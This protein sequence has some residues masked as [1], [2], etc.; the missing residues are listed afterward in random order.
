MRSLCL[1]VF[2]VGVLSL[3]GLNVSHATYSYHNQQHGYWQGYGFNKKFHTFKHKKS[4]HGFHHQ[5]WNRAPIAHH[6]RVWLKQGESKSFKLSATDWDGDTLTYKI[7]RDPRHGMLTGDAPNLVYTPRP[8]FYGK[9]YLK[10]VVSDGKKNSY[11]WVKFYVKRNPLQQNKAPVANEQSLTTRVNTSVDIALTGS[12]AENDPLTFS[13]SQIPVHGT[14]S[15]TAPNLVYTPNPNFVGDDAFAFIANDGKKDS[16]PATVSIS[17]KPKPLCRPNDAITLNYDSFADASDWQ[18]NGSANTLTPNADKVLR[19]TQQLSQGGSAFIRDSIR[20]EDDNGFKA[21]FSAAFSFRIP[22]PIGIQDRDGQGADGIVFVLQ[23]MA[24]NVGANGGGIGYQGIKNSLGIEFDTWDNGKVDHYS[25]NHIGI[26]VNGS[27]RSKLIKPI[28]GRFNDGDRRYVWVDYHGDT[29]RLEIRLAKEETRPEKPVMVVRSLDLPKILGK[30]DAFVG[31]TSG[32]GAAGGQHDLIDFQLVNRYAPIDDCRNT[33]PAAD[34]QSLQTNQNQPLDITLTGSD[35]D[36]D[37]V[38]F[39]VVSQPANGQLSGDAP[40]L[41]YTPNLDFIGTD[42]ITFIANDGIVDSVEATIQIT[43]LTV[44][45]APV[46]LDQS[47]TLDEDTIIDLQLTGTDGDNDPLSYTLQSQPQNGTLTGTAP[48]LI[49]TPNA[50]FSG[51]DS[52]TFLVNDG[53]VDSAIATITLT[54]NPMNDAPIA[55]S[56]S[57]ITPEDA[58]LTILLDGSDP[59]GNT[60]TYELVRPAVNGVISGTVPNLVYTPASNFVGSDTFTFKVNDGTADSNEATVTITVTPVNDAPVADDQS[61]TTNEDSPVSIE[62]T[63]SDIDG[64]SLSFSVQAQPINGTLSGTVPNLTYTPNVDFNGNDSF[65]FVVNDGTVDSA[66]ATVSI[67]VNPVNDA[68]TADDQGI[69]TDEDVVVNIALTGTDPEGDAISYVVQ[70][71]PANGTLSGTAPNLTYTPNTDFTGSDSFTFV[72]NDGTIDSAIATVSIVVNPVNDAPTADD[73]SITTDEDVAVNIALTGTDPEGDVLSYVVQNQPANGTLSGTAPNLTYTPNT[74]FAGNDSFTFV[75]NDGTIDSAIATVSITM[76]PINDAPIAND[77]SITTDEDVAVNIILTG[78]DPEGDSL[79]YVVQTQPANGTLSGTAPDLTYTPNA[80]FTGNDSFTFIVNDGAVESTVATVSITVNPTND[81]PTADDQSITT[82]EDVAVNIILTGNDPEGDSLTYVVQTQ[83]ANGTLSGTAPDLTYTPNADFTG[84]DSFTF[85]VNDGTVDSAIATL[86]IVVNS[87]NDAPTADDQSITT[88]EDVAVNIALTGTDPEGDALNYVVQTQPENGSLSGTAP[89][90]TYTPNA[91][92]TGSDTF[93]FVVNDGTVESAVA[94]VSITVNPVNDAPTADDQIITTDEDTAVN[95]IL[96]GADPEGD[97]LT[98][99]VQTQP[100]NGTLSGAAPDLTYTPDVGFSGNDSFTFVVNDGTVNSSIATVFITVNSITDPLSLS[101]TPFSI[102]TV[103]EGYRYEIITN[104]DVSAVTFSLLESP[105]GMQ[106]DDNGVVTWVP[107]QD[108]IGIHAVDA[109]V[110]DANGQQTNQQWDIEVTRGS[111]QLTPKYV[112]ASAN[113]VSTIHKN[114][115]VSELPNAL[116]LCLVVDLSGS[117]GN[118]LPNI[119]NKAP[120]IFDEVKRGIPDTQFCLASFVDYPFGGYGGA[121]D[122][123]H[124]LHQDLTPVREFWLDEVNRLVLRSGGDG[125]ESQLESLYQLATGSGRDVGDAGASVGD[126]PAGLN[127]SFR[128]DAAKIIAITTDAPFHDS[129]AHPGPTLDETVEALN[130]AGIAIIAIKAPGASEQ[131]D[132]LA[133]RTG[134]IVVETSSDS[135]EIADAVIR[136]VRELSRKV[137]HRTVSCDVADIS[138]DKDEAEIFGR[139]VVEFVET[140]LP[141]SASGNCIIEYSSKGEILGLQEINFCE[142]WSE[143]YPPEIISTPSTELNIEDDYYYAVIASDA[144]GDKLSYELIA[145]P[146]GMQINDLGEVTWQPVDSQRGMNRVEVQVTDTDGATDTQVWDIEVGDINRS[147]EIVSTPASEVSLFHEFSYYLIVRDADDDNHVYELVSAPMG[148]QIAGNIISWAPQDGTLGDHEFVVRATDAEGLSDE[149]TFI[150][151]VIP[152]QG[153]EFVSTPATERAYQHVFSYELLAED[154]ERDRVTGYRLGSGSGDAAVSGSTFTWTVTNPVGTETE[155]TVEALDEYGA[156]GQQTFIVKSVEN[157]PMTITSDPALTGITRHEYKYTPT[158]E[159]ADGDA[160]IVELISGP[161]GLSTSGD[162]LVW[163]PT[164]A[165]V[166]NFPVSFRVRD[167]F[168]SQDEQSYVINVTLNQPPEF[169]SD[170]LDKA[171]AGRQYLYAFNATD[172]D[173][174]A[175]SYELITA[176]DGMTQV[177]R[178]LRWNPVQEQIGSSYDVVLQADDQFGGITTQAFT[179]L[180]TGNRAPEFTSTPDFFGRVGEFYFYRAMA[181]D[182]DGDSVI[183]SLDVAPDGMT[184]SGNG[185][186]WTPTATQLGEHEVKVRADDRNG[187]VVTQSFV[188]NV[189]E[190][191]APQFTS[192]PLVNVID[193][194]SYFYRAIATDPDNDSVIYSLTT[195]P[196]GMT[197]SGN[198]IRWTPDV[199]QTGVHDVVILADDRKGGTTEQAYQIT[200][201]SNRAPEFTSSPLE[202]VIEG[203][204]YFYRSIAVDPDGDSLTY[205]LEIAPDGMT[206]SGNFIRWTPDNSQLG[207][208][209]V[210]VV[211]DDRFGKTTTQSFAVTVFENQSP[212]IVAEPNTAGRLGVNY[213]SRLIATDPDGDSVQY[214]LISG[215]TGLSVRTNGFIDWANTDLLLG[216][217]EIVLEAFDQYD[218]VTEYRYRLTIIDSDLSITKAP[219]D[220]TLFDNELFSFRAEAVHFEGRGITYEFTESPDGATI[221]PN[222]GQI[223]WTPTVS[224]LGA[225]PFILRAFSSDG[226]EDT[227]SFTITVEANTNQSPEITSSPVLT[228]QTGVSYEYPVVATDAE[229][230]TLTYSL[231]QAPSGMRVNA[232]SGV[233]SWNVPNAASS[234][235]THP[236]IVRVT[237]ERGKFTEQSYEL[238]IALSNVAP[239]ITSAAFTVGKLGFDYAYP[240]EATDANGDV[241]TYSLPIAPTGMTINTDGLIQ[242]T[243]TT[244][245]VFPVE[246]VV[247]DGEFTD[248]QLFQVAVSPEEPALE[249]QITLSPTIVDADENVL[250]SSSALNNTGRAFGTLTLDGT[251]VV[252][253]RVLPFNWNVSSSDVGEHTVEL[254]VIDSYQTATQTQIFRVRDDNDTDAPFAQIHNIEQDQVITAPVEVVA[255][256]TDSNFA[257]WELIVREVVADPTEFQVLASG[258]T[259]INEAMVATLDP[260]LLRNG[261]YGLILRV[262]DLNGEETLESVIV[263][264]D[265][266]LKVGNFSVTYEDLNIPLAGIPISVRRTYDSRD[267]AKSMDFGFGWSLDYNN[268]KVEESRRPGFGWAQE[269]SGGLIPN[270][271]IEPLGAPIVTVTLPDGDVESFEAAASPRCSQ[272]FPQ[273]NVT[274]VFNPVGDTQSTLTAVDGSAYYDSGNLLKDITDVGTDNYANPDRYRLTSKAGFVFDLDQNLGIR[275]VTDPNGNVLTYTDE[276]IIHSDGKRVDF[277]RDAEGRIVKITDPSGKFLEYDYT[278]AGDLAKAIERDGAETTF[279]YNSSHGLIDIND[280]LGRNI[281]KNI[282]DDAGRLI[283]QEDSDGNRTEFNH[284]VDGRQSIVTDRNGNITQL[285]YDDDG[286]VTTQIDALGNSTSYTH[287]ANGNETSQANALG[288]Q[289]QATFNDRNDQL[290]Q[291]DA[292]GNVTAFEYNDRGKETKLTDARGNAFN[293]VYDDNNNLISVTDPLGN[294]ATTTLNRQGLPSTVTDVLGNTTQFTYD[295][296]G[297]KLTETDSEGNVMRFTRDANGNAL[298][299]TRTRLIAGVATEETTTYEYD[300]R[301]RVVKTIDALGNETQTEYNLVGNEVAQID[302]LGRRTEMEYDAY[303]RLTQTTYPDGTVETKT[304]DPEGNLLTDTDRLGRLMTYEYDALNRLIK[305]TQADGSVTSTEYDAIGRVVAEVDANG[306]RTV[307]EYDAADRRIKTTD[308]LGNETTFAY[309]ADGNMTGMTDANGNTTTYIY[310][311]LDQKVQTTFA[312]TSTM[313]EGLDALSRKTSMTDQAGV[314]TNYEYDKLGRLVKVIDAL[315]QETAY[316]YDSVG[317]KLTQT[318]AEGRTTTW[319]YDA[320]G[321]VISRTLPLGQQETFVYD[322]VGNLIEHTDFKGQTTTHSYDVNNRLTQSLYADGLME[323]FVYDAVGN[324]TQANK[325]ENSVTTTTNYVYDTQNRLSSETQFVG[326]ADEVTLSYVYDAQGNRTQLTEAQGAL[327]RVTNYTFD[328]LN[329]LSTVTDPEANVTTYQYDAVGNRSGMTHANGN[330]VNY[331]YDELNRLTTLNHVDSADAIIKGFAYTLH[332]TGRRTQI[333][334]NSGRTTTYT[335][336]TLYRLTTENITDSVNGNHS[337]EYTYDKVGNRTF[338]VVNG[339][340]TA[341]MVDDNDRLVQTG[342]N[343]YTHDANGNTLTQTLDGVVTTYTYNAKNELVGS[344][345]A[346]SATAYL[347]NTEGVRIGK[348]DSTSQTLYTVD[349]NRDY[350]QVLAESVNG[351][352]AVNYTYGDDLISQ[353]RGTQTSTYHYDGLGSTRALSDQTGAIANEYDYEAF[354]EV[355]NQTGTTEND[356]LFTGEQFDSTLGMSYLRQRY[357]NQNVGRFHTMD[358]WMGVNSDP[359]TLH[360]YLYANVD[361]ANMVDPSGNFG[362]GGFGAGIGIGLNIASFGLTAFDLFSASTDEDGLTPKEVGFLILTSMNPAKFARFFRRGCK[363]NSFD[364]ETLVSTDRGLRPIKNI[365][366]GDKVWAYNEITGEKMLQEVVHLIFGEGEKQLIDITLENGEVITA[367]DEHPFYVEGKWLDAEDLT[368]KNQLLSFDDQLLAIAN[369]ESYSRQ[370]S[371]YNLTVN[372]DHTYYVGNEKVLSHNAGGCKFKNIVLGP[373]AKPP[374]FRHPKHNGG[375]GKKPGEDSGA[376]PYDSEIALEKFSYKVKDKGNSVGKWYARSPDGKSIY[377]YCGDKSGVYHWC[378]GTAPGQGGLTATDIPNDIIK[379]LGFSKKG[380]NRPR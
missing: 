34:D 128:S 361:P 237:D 342:G 175:I 271:C 322:E 7:I 240:V 206:I 259:E 345:E 362:I 195:A 232:T 22:K 222:T 86:S 380:A 370:G 265:E 347:Y 182:P 319:A 155:F 360:K 90:L 30:S 145:S 126:I 151:E 274:I 375:K 261:Q 223:E 17:V 278:A 281:V 82:D 340:S 131:M 18:L 154:P 379:A 373:V 302:A 209:P 315:G 335:Y 83:P 178:T 46:A 275:S 53:T 211:A 67:I 137:T 235:T 85:V 181:V 338:E 378:G 139:S 344:N 51:T 234:A 305:T 37:A 109:L 135:S 194:H 32:T 367:T 157:S 332:P 213:F 141:N 172:P 349:H 140:A 107:S 156:V 14:L 167:G 79:T 254:T 264:I 355:L 309:D 130:N 371:V 127:P 296:D 280:P 339:V 238:V 233:V 307:H 356:Y 50:E 214:R 93:T 25:G 115:F 286:Y 353:K 148:A 143:N 61:V 376:E 62:L 164:D 106:V 102:A 122:Y 185:I 152:N 174:D 60:L 12:D 42:S 70:T 125:N 270:I 39:S 308:A 250:V 101:C 47:F 242:W 295:L 203:H 365:K 72:V 142:A 91:D 31:F 253:N 196:N 290:T 27:I 38:T 132:E 299:E 56:Q 229:G 294:M 288:H 77:Q 377:Q 63:G 169:T 158:V 230:H 11:A 256:A 108:Q 45:A 110:E 92:F 187:A 350:A 119:R 306:N 246:L 111:T 80:D 36:G 1:R 160:A 236:V 59:E 334:E 244:V 81:A 190:N 129:D 341:Y 3:C 304:Y 188:V 257:S 75:V 20:L 149:Q 343:L 316:T 44:N 193:S 68:P 273:N 40:N 43:V 114:V 54:V 121:S 64:D 224:Q 247:T 2:F 189:I 26:N 104:M 200:V 16:S 279:A 368:R 100:A 184:I 354:G 263:K 4:K 146:D 245:G 262:R 268:I 58:P 176:P 88:D 113:S 357:Y 276:G 71:Q 165:Q 337:A 166:G 292:L 171:I 326:T 369:I 138:F 372:N 300:E 249:A 66:V 95:I 358:T 76:N 366:I 180:V 331:A 21:S 97:T 207:I 28:K 318:D 118:D 8:G 94:T 186:R 231:T 364:G 133:E 260:S 10:F 48:N 204:S 192:T 84:N 197:I 208:H 177:G 311:A 218:G 269:T 19:L 162:S 205:S 252:T 35:V 303:N 78:N 298:T 73:Q 285:F 324:R 313:L 267:R 134:G 212:V 216:D 310:N 363:P 272:L 117:Y 159:D 228:G 136:G 170:A 41:I 226:L 13:I 179:V 198:F 98:Y 120:E 161:V 328:V 266:E 55:Q 33:P 297:Y 348:G 150:L 351:T 251:I 312:N 243:P 352:L 163:T 283:A 221:V 147:P 248:V 99:V 52:F 202:S 241:L 282:Y 191:R 317:N 346:G 173:G 321:R 112:K 333:T 201:T 124:D 87:V 105:Q 291:V 336:D 255:T 220:Q 199:S 287:D 327:T 144:N 217:H 284:D 49:Y 329:R 96:T 6:S 29:Q 5:H 168:G 24:N 219:T 89:D 359:V 153:P 65:T 69:T 215:P 123:A 330:K 320:L 289:T 323:T 74:D 293:N 239:R 277:T 314:V 301:D 183:Y 325:T 15:G 225:N 374:T 57:L 210:S 9:D 227:A 258:T 103:N 116:D 23:T